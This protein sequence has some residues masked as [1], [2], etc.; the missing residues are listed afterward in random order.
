LS[1]RCLSKSP[2]VSVLAGPTQAEN[3]IRRKRGD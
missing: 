1:R 3:G 2:A